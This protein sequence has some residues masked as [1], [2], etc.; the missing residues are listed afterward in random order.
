M[1][2][3]IMNHSAI[4]HNPLSLS[5]NL[6]STVEA[7][8]ASTNGHEHV[9]GLLLVFRVYYERSIVIDSQNLKLRQIV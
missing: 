4:H 9:R 2:C 3:C 7:K 5:R 1:V 8:I 6:V